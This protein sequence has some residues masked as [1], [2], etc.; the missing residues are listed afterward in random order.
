MTSNIGSNWIKE[1]GVEGARD[2]V[3]QELNRVFRPEF[4]NRIDEVI[5]FQALTKEHLRQVVDL[6]LNDLKKRL[7]ERNIELEV[8]DEAKSKLADEGFDPVLGARPLKR[9]IQKRIQNVLALKLLRG[10]IKAGERVVVDVAPNGEFEFIA[11]PAS[12]TEPA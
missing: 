5:L 6:Q 11:Q 8:T 12:E 9:V 4:L 2:Q 1:L 3:M 10:E 7:A